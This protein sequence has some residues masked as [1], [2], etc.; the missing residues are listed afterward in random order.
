MQ[1]PNG[2]IER[3]AR[4]AS[5]AGH[6]GSDKMLLALIKVR[7]QQSVFRLKFVRFVHSNQYN[8]IPSICHDYLFTGSN[9]NAWVR[10]V[11]KFLFQ[12]SLCSVLRCN[13]PRPNWI[14][15]IGEPNYFIDQTIADCQNPHQYGDSRIERCFVVY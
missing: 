2:T 8:T 11:V 7:K 5:E 12:S 3:G 1:A 14:L 4:Q 10:Q 15:R 6:E 9:V 13:I